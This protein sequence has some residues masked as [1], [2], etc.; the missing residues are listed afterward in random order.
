MCAFEIIRITTSE[1]KQEK[2]CSNIIDRNLANEKTDQQWMERGKMQIKKL[3][4]RRMS[5]AKIYDEVS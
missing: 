1:E 5:K 2:R 4:K 3:H